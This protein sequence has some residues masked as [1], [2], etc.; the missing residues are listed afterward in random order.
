MLGRSYL[1]GAIPDDWITMWQSKA[2]VKMPKTWNED[3][4]GYS[5]IPR[6]RDIEEKNKMMLARVVQH[7]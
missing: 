2:Q 7:Y 5:V 3:L 4:Q 6:R 1:E